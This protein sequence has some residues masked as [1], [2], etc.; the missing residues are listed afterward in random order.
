MKMIST[1][2]NLK[3]SRTGEF[4]VPESAAP[5]R[6]SVDRVKSLFL[7]FSISEFNSTSNS[8]RAHEELT[9]LL[10][11]EP[12][13]E[14]ATLKD[15]PEDQEDEGQN[16]KKGTEK[17][18]NEENKDEDPKSSTGKPPENRGPRRETYKQKII[19]T[20]IQRFA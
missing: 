9:D 10:P 7:P 2:L 3:K 20:I 11:L 15:E 19:D 12:S 17:K 6:F 5:E 18:K 16:H 13:K 1:K 14:V 4:R 8:T